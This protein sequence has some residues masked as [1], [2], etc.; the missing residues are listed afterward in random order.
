[1][2]KTTAI[3]LLLIH[4]YNLIGYHALFAFLQK[5]STSHIISKLD[6]GHYTDQDLIEVKIPYKLLYASNWPRYERYDGEMERNGI[7]YNYVKRKFANDTLYL[8]CI[9]NK[10]NTNLAFAKNKYFN[11]INDAADQAGKKEKPA[12]RAIKAFSAEY[13]H[14]V[15]AFTFSAPCRDIHSERDRSHSKLSGCFLATPN[16]PP[17]A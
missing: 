3:L 6:R 17:R 12:S 10:E 7:H 14:A 1:M 13:N 5:K 2:R 11:N 4:A 16:E 9:P 15:A 8:M